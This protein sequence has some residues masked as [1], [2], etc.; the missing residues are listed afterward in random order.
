MNIQKS[1]IQINVNG[2]SANAYL[3][4]GGGAGV[5]VLHAWWGLSLSFKQV[6]DRLAEQGYTALAPDLYLGDIAK[7]ID[8]AKALLGKYDNELKGSIVKAAKEHLALF[9]PDKPI[10]AVGFS[11]GAGWALDMAENDPNVSAVIMFYGAGEADYDKV[12]AKVLGHF[13]EVDEWEP[14]DY[15]KEMEQAMKDGGVD[16]TLHFYPKVAHWFMESDR[17]EYDS[18]TAQLAWKRTFEFLNTTL[19]GGS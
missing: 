15:V 6:C 1:E 14:L 2:K 19:R 3:A 17:P 13:A 7:T 8:E 9:R 5:L 11:M 4:D 10:A 18:E 16:V 12:K